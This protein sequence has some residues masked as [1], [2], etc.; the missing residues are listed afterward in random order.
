VTTSSP[1]AP[2]RAVDA[3]RQSSIPSLRSLCVEETDT[4]VIIAGQVASYYLKQ[5]AQETIMP[6]LA[7]RELHNCVDV[8]RHRTD[9]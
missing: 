2:S 3:L 9:D 4:A 6:V 8:V 7:G 5:L 1:M